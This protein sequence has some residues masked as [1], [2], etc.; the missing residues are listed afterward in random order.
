MLTVPEPTTTLATV[1]FTDIVGSTE[2]AADLGDRRWQE[3]L[4]R[5]HAVVRKELRHSGGRE[6]DTAGDSFFATFTRPASAIRCAWAIGDRLQE[7]GIEVRAGVHT[8]EVAVR[9]RNLGGIAV[10]IG[11]RVAALAG[12][13]EVIVT[14]TVRDLVSGSGIGFE[15]RGIRH[16]KGIPGTWPLFAVTGVEGTKREAPLTAEVARE[17]RQA[18]Q[19]PSA[20]LRRPWLAAGLTG[21]LILAVVAA[22]LT[23]GGKAAPP[24]P[25]GIPPGSA[26]QLDPTTG[27]VLAT[28]SGLPGARGTA[29]PIVVGEGAVWVYMNPHLIHVDPA[30]G[31]I[32]KIIPVRFATSVVVGFRQVWLASTRP[33]GISRINPATDEPL[34]PINLP[35]E[36]SSLSPSGFAT[37][38]AA[39]EGAVWETWGNGELIRID[40]REG[41]A[42]VI[43]LDANLFGVAAGEGSVWVGNQLEGSI[44]P[45][46][47]A[48][49]RPGKPI[50][51]LG[52][53]DAIVAG[54]GRV[55]ILDKDI[56]TV[57]PVDPS[58]GPQRG[59]RVGG[60]PTD[61]VTGLGALWVSDQTGTITRIDALTLEKERFDLH[62]PLS[63]IAIDPDGETLWVLASESAT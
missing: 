13:G 26:V 36:S 22:T 17:R 52:N 25:Q 57:T 63:G 32:D 14:S 20:L 31:V 30:D 45:V 51:V 19:A 44:I 8:G 10:H 33:N 5:H 50:E 60:T 53:V 56:G 42:R 1:L 23:L 46:D 9:R 49:G 6:V 15:E 29:G 37:G 24:P 34:P 21:S 41:G 16:L 39:G 4:R 35:H 55:W 54:E 59:V 27:E 47:P 43:A 58:A 11:A 38:L 61:L 28:V 62:T 12:P 18:I 3:L 40:P 7:L 2:I 48:T